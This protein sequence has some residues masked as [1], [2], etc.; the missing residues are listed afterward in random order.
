MKRERTIFAAVISAAI[1]LLR[2]VTAF[3]D[4]VAP[5]PVEMIRGNLGSVL[6]TIVIIILAVVVVTGIVLLIIFRRRRKNR[7]RKEES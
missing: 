4:A 5:G 3:A 2:E 1:L 7:E 6:G